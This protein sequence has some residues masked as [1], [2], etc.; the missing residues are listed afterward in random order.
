MAGNQKINDFINR[1]PFQL[2]VEPQKENQA[3]ITPW[4][5]F[6]GPFER[7][8]ASHSKSCATPNLILQSH[9]SGQPKAAQACPCCST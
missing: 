8:S 7:A 6:K 5:Q 3:E 9:S 4:L 2:H 1:P